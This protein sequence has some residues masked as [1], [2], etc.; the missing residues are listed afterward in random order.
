MTKF[1]A[2]FHDDALKAEAFKRQRALIASV[3]L[4]ATDGKLA[5]ELRGEFASM[6]ELPVCGGQTKT[7]SSRTA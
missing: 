4:T 6:L 5:I 3:V 1:A 2:A 7:P